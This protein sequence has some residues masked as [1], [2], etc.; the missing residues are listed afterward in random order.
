[1]DHAEHAG[2]AGVPSGV[3][4][5]LR[6]RGIEAGGFPPPYDLVAKALA[7]TLAWKDVSPPPG[8]LRPFE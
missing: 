1:M 4:D 6:Q 8:V 2:A 7:S 5:A 3:I